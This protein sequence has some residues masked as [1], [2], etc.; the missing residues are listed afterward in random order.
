MKSQTLFAYSLQSN[1]SINSMF[2]AHRQITMWTRPFVNIPIF[3]P[4]FLLLLPFSS[5]LLHA[6]CTF[7]LHL[8][9]RL[10]AL[11]RQIW[12]HGQLL[13]EPY[14]SLLSCLLL[15]WGDYT[16]VMYGESSLLHAPFGFPLGLLY[17]NIVSL[18]MVSKSRI[19]VNA[20]SVQSDFGWLW[21]LSAFD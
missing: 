12:N 14:V 7:P 17:F 4:F 10:L 16:Y 9:A 8:V 1:S 21:C 15:N 11:Y 2:W 3:S 19:K 6:K 20:A 13:L 5:C 18:L